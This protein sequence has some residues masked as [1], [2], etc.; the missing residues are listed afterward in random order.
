MTEIIL[1]LQGEIPKG[2]R[3]GVPYVAGKYVSS[4]NYFQL[5]LGPLV[6][7]KPGKTDGLG[8]LTCQKS[9]QFILKK[10]KV[11]IGFGSKWGLTKMDMG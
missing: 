4:E 3:L 11:L 9:K 7:H 5:S 1:G 8:W 6:L 2:S 10:L